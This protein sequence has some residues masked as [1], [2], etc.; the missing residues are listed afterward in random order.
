MLKKCPH[1]LGLG[2][3]GFPRWLAIWLKRVLVPVCTTEQP[4]KS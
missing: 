4:Q 2:V 1:F 3:M